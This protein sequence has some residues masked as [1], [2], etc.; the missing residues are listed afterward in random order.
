MEFLVC[1]L[2]V[3][4]LLGSIP[5]ALI[6]GKW[7][8]KIDI[9][10]QGSGN[11]GATNAFRVLGK[12]AGILVSLGDVSKGLLAACLPTMFGI[13][14]HPLFPG[15][16][17]IIGHCYP[18]FANFKGGKAVATSSGVFLAVSPV[19]FLLGL[20][21]F[22]ITLKISKYV[23]LSSTVSS[24]IIFLTSLFIGDYSLIIFTSIIF[25]FITYKHKTNYTRI[26]LKTEPKVK[27]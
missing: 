22:F 4:Y 12:K 9:R 25:V 1:I 20:I 7:F 10:T 13:D 24:F 15:L 19:V 3:A 27:W 23:S 8:Y 17:A 14:L 6:V 2:V 11:L 5:F 21:T 18:V 26:K 16:L